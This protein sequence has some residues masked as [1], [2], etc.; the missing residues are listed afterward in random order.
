MGGVGCSPTPSESAR[1]SEGWSVS[2]PFGKLSRRSNGLSVCAMHERV[3]LCRNLGLVC[4][5]EYGSADRKSTSELSAHRAAVRKCFCVTSA[6]WPRSEPTLFDFIRHLNPPK[7]A[8][9][10]F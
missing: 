10:I 2:A 7:M 6:L 8:G 9:Q 3:P 5:S 4:C 1:P